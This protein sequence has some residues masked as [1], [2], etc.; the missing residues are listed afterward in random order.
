MDI[1]G[2]KE[3]KNGDEFRQRIRAST[4]VIV[5]TKNSKILNTLIENF[6][7]GRVRGLTCLI[8]DDEADQASLNTREFFVV[9]RQWCSYTVVSGISTRVPEGV[10]LIPPPGDDDSR[11]VLPDAEAI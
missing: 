4:C 6:K 7:V 9:M 5:T 3:F 1:I 11:K 2:R 10:C 8:I